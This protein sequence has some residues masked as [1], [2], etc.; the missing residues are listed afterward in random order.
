MGV[1]YIL[2]EE[3]IKFDTQAV[4][5]ICRSGRGSLRD[6]LTITDQ[7]IAYCDGHLT[8][9]GIAQMLGTLPF[10]HVNL[11]L[12]FIAKKVLGTIV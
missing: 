8:D 6:C 7:A 11:L 1:S 9:E 5:Q 2:K 12:S 4:E 3:Q 10:D